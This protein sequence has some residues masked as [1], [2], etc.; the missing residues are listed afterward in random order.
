MHTTG[1][2][3]ETIDST[4]IT[5]NTRFFQKVFS[6][7]RCYMLW[8]LTAALTTPGKHQRAKIILMN[9]TLRSAP[10][11]STTK[12]CLF[13]TIK[14]KSYMYAYSKETLLLIIYRPYVY[15]AAAKFLIYFR[16]RGHFILRN[17]LC[18]DH[19]GI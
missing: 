1:N 14:F 11:P 18:V 7:N 16:V 19:E 5:C 10:H 15:V 2:P 6:C 8:P 12:W 9:V 13:R 4:L 17:K 3:V